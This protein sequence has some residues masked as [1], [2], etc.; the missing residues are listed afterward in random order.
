MA[1]FAPA[2]LSES[3]QKV[4]SKSDPKLHLYT[5]GTPNGHKASILLEELIAAYPDSPPLYDFIPIS[6]AENTQKTP[7]FLAINPNGRIPALVD[8]NTQV[9]GKGHN[10]FESVSILLWLVEKYDKD[11]KFWFG[12][13]EDVLRS[14]AFSWMVS[15]SLC[16]FD[17]RQPFVW[18]PSCLWQ[19]EC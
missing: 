12:E 9:D 8:D 11:N 15:F 6:F 16:L 10:V 14:K 1:P 17:L 13:G 5:V 19:V 3:V 4:G 7:E 2:E 18:I